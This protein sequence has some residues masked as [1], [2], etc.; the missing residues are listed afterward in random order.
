MNAKDVIKNN[1]QGGQMILGALIEDLSDDELFVRPAGA[2]NHIAFQ[3]GHLISSERTMID[4]VCPG[5]CPELPSGFEQAHSKENSKNDA[6]DGFLTKKEYLG[7]YQKQR[8]ATLKALDSLPD[9][10]LDKPGPESLRQ[11]CPTVGSVFALQP[12]HQVWHMGQLTV[13]RRQLNKPVV[14]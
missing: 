10:D 7:L 6:R 12:I 2:A 3:L 8:E 1:I 11:I 9:A 14:F 13:L 5:T 4:G